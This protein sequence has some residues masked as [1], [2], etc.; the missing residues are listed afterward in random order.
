LNFFIKIKRFVRIP[1]IE[2]SNH[3]NG[4]LKKIIKQ[5]SL[6]IA[7]LRNSRKFSKKSLDLML[8]FIIGIDS[9]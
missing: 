9:I 3:G 8:F 7:E 2:L 1:L 4:Y 6:K 5:K